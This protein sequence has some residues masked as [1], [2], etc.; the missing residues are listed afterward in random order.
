VNIIVRVA[1]A[2]LF[3]SETKRGAGSVA[4]DAI[5]LFM[6]TFEWEVRKLM[7][8]CCRLKLNDVGIPAFMLLVTG[9]TTRVGSLRMQSV[10]TAA[11]DTILLHV[12]VTAGAQHIL[13]LRFVAN[14][15]AITAL[16][17]TGMR[18][19]HRPWHNQ[20][21]DVEHLRGSALTDAEAHD[22][23]RSECKAGT[24]TMEDIGHQ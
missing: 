22:E 4:V 1:I 3:F 18:L 8:E 19:N 9:E 10:E 20:S 5:R 7:I 11:R 2:A 14:V 15:T 13:T 17:D 21:L 6:R 24:V 12:S 23:H 16:F